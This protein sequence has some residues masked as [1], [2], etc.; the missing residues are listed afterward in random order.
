MNALLPA[1][2]FLVA[3]VAAKLLSYLVDDLNPTGNLLLLNERANSGHR[4]R[5]A[6][7]R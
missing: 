6:R 2:C 3:Q 1:I 5:D 4:L 7:K